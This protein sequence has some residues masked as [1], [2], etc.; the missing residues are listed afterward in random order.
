MTTDANGMA[1]TSS[2]AALK[3]LERDS[4]MVRGYC[5]ATEDDRLLGPS[6]DRTNTRW[7]LLSERGQFYNTM[8]QI[9]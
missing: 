2:C 5:L 7:R 9:Y 3:T 8:Q 6:A 4:P 1:L